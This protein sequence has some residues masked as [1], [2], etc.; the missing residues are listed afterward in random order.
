MTCR[1]AA[2]F[3]T[4]RTKLRRCFEPRFF[5]NIRAFVTKKRCCCRKPPSNAIS[6]LPSQ[7]LKNRSDIRQAELELQ[8]T[9]LDVQVEFNKANAHPLQ[10]LYEYQKSVINGYVEVPNEMSA[11]KNLE[12]L[13]QTKSSE[14]TALTR[15]IDVAKDMFKSFG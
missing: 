11:L 6:C 2:W 10:A 5:E 4:S 7:L 15:S 12:Q 8:T 3:G 1:L 13:H 14:A 9:K